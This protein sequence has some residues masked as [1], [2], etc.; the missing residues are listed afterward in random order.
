MLHVRPQKIRECC[1]HAAECGEKARQT[2]DPDRQTFWKERKQ[3]W[4]NL[5]QS[6][7]FSVQIAPMT[8]A[9]ADLVH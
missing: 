5:A 7:E 3:F 2:R 6:Y 1:R 4:L 8:D 9:R